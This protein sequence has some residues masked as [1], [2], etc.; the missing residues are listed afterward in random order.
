MPI[1]WKV[2]QANSLL[3]PSDPINGRGQILLPGIAENGLR[4]ATWWPYRPAMRRSLSTSARRSAVSRVMVR[5]PARKRERTERSTP[6]AS[7]SS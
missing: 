2:A 4:P 7:A 5:L 1:I 3:S 6:E